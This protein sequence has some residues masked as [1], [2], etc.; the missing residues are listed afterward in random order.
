MTATEKRFV[1][2]ASLKIIGSVSAGTY[3]GKEAVASGASDIGMTLALMGGIT[4]GAVAG[5]TLSVVIGS[6]LE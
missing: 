6:K 4:I 1:L 5:S 2:G 3:L